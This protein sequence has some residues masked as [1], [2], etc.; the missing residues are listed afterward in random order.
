[1]LRKDDSNKILKKVKAIVFA[2]S[3]SLLNP[4]SVLGNEIVSQPIY[5]QDVADNDISSSLETLKI[6]GGISLVIFTMGI[7]GAKFELNNWEKESNNITDIYTGP[8]VDNDV[9][10]DVNDAVKYLKLTNGIENKQ[11]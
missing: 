6:V 4:V 7:I 1:M 11:C 9:N 8:F 10:D 5:E 3:L 2:T